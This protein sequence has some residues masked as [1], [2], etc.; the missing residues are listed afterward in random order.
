[1]EPTTAARRRCVLR[2]RSN[3]HKYRC[4]STSPAPMAPRKALARLQPLRLVCML[5]SHYRNAELVVVAAKQ[6]NHSN[7]AVVEQHKQ[8]PSPR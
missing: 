3:E 5:L 2:A 6:R 7:I 1:M 8:T 4:E